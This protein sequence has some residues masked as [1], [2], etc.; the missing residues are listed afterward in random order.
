MSVNDTFGAIEIPVAPASPTFTPLF[1]PSANDPSAVA[2]GDPCLSVILDYLATFLVTDKAALEA[3]QS[4]AG[5]ESPVARVFPHNPAD[6]AFSVAFLPALFM[7]R[8]SATNAWA[9]ED[10]LRETTVVKSLWVWKPTT[11]AKE[12]IRTPMVNGIVKAIN[13]GIERGR[14]PSWKQPGDVDPLTVTFGSLFWTY[15]AFEGFELTSYTTTRPLI[16]QNQDGSRLY[17][18]AIELTFT[19]RENLD[20]GID[21]LDPLGAADLTVTDGTTTIEGPI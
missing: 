6:A 3:W 20:V 13:V 17:Y 21:G 9:A 12:R 15:A 7:W 14:T 1:P 11:Q 18:P 16:V 2:V 10:W 4:V 5:G 8:E 19:L